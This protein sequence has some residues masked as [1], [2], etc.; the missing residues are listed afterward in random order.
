MKIGPFE[1][2][3][4][5]HAANMRAIADAATLDQDTAPRRPPLPIRDT[6]GSEILRIPYFPAPMQRL[7]DLAFHSDLLRV[8]V[9][10][11]Q[12]AVVREG[13]EMVPNFAFRCDACNLDFDQVQ[14]N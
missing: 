4:A 6:P 9:I 14:D 3:N 7:Y 2:M 10:Q 11:K 12:E 5:R 13:I 8:I 1:V